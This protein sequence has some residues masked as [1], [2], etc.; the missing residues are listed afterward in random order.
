MNDRIHIGLNE[1][2]EI[3]CK[4]CIKKAAE[5][6]KF[7]SSTVGKGLGDVVCVECMCVLN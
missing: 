7:M 5:D 6:E 3:T 2:K 1:S 4:E